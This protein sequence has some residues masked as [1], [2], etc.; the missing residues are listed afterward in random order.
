MNELFYFVRNQWL[1]A[2]LSNYIWLRI[3]W[4]LLIQKLFKFVQTLLLHCSVVDASLENQDACNLQDD[5]EKYLIACIIL[6]KHCTNQPDFWGGGEMQEEMW[7]ESSLKK[8]LLSSL[9]D[10]DLLL[11]HF[12][13]VLRSPGHVLPSSWHFLAQKVLH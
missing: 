10:S 8:L 1:T 11:N 5:P 3:S 6:E 4:V 12:S 2:F 7:D 13:A 9:L